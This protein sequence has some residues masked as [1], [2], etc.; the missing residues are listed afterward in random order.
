RNKLSYAQVA[1]T[2][3]VSLLHPSQTEGVFDEVTN[4]VIQSR[5]YRNS[6]TKGAYLFDFSTIRIPVDEKISLLKKQHP[7]CY[8]LLQKK[9]RSVEYFEVYIDPEDD[10]NDILHTGVYFDTINV[11]VLPCKAL[12]DNSQIVQI[13]LTDLPMYKPHVVLK[14]LNASLEVFGDIIDI[15]LH[16][17]K[18]NEMYLGT[19]YA[20][21]DLW[22]NDGEIA[23]QPLAHT[24]EWCESEE[25]EFHATW[26][27]M[28]T[29]CRFCHAEG[30]TKYGC[31]KSRA[32][33]ICYTCHELGH[34]S[35]ECPRAQK[36]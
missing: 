2:K 27:N 13:N 23:F 24:I 16:F 35:F 30:H 5:V 34:R 3:K 26:S 17:D 1:S 11:R 29:W 32:R 4:L 33:I 12:R 6:R 15:G 21:L 36:N 22:D 25:E 9:D 20:V 18:K 19:E 8:G 31:E 7:E 28:P 14:G 10:S